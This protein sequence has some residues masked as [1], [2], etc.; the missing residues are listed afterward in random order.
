VSKEPF[1]CWL[2][3]CRTKQ[4]RISSRQRETKLHHAQSFLHDAK[5]KN[6][7]H[8]PRYSYYICSKI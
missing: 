5:R 2:L 7:F 8:L 6:Y 3:W 4:N 1:P